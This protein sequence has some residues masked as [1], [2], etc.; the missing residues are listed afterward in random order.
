MSDI[1]REID[2]DLR[3]DRME[4]VWKRYGGILLAGAITIVAATGGWVAWDRWQTQR[5]SETTQRL[6]TA[7]ATEDTAARLND[8]S[9]FAAQA[10]TGPATLA[11]LYEAGLRA[12]QGDAKAAIA[13]YDQVAADGATEGVW[14]DLATLLSVMH[15]VGSGDAVALQARITPLSADANP[16]RH[17]AREV[18]ALLAL[19]AGDTARARTL[20]QQL[21]DDADAPA[22]VRGRAG[23]LAAQ[24]GAEQEGKS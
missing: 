17:S 21:A 23:D 13:L 2:E 6:V 18:M 19:Q 3:R 14:R 10:P 9:A 7:L 22:G 1:F 11:R 5:Q 4:R 24:Y 20:F 8:L 12:Q 16:W 15:Q